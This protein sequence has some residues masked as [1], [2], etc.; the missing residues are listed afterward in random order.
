M[1][2][3]VDITGGAHVMAELS[4]FMGE[5]FAEVNV[6]RTRFTRFSMQ[7]IDMWCGFGPNMYICLYG[8]NIK[9]MI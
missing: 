8:V 9:L 5:L 3:F 7:Q 4:G 1:E 6:L 2:H